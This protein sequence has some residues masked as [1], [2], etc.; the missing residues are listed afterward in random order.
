[1]PLIEAMQQ[2]DLNLKTFSSWESVI[3]ELMA[4]TN[5]PQSTHCFRLSLFKTRPSNK[6]VH[7]E[8][9]NK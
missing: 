8:L 4:C 3:Q 2:I 7:F 5:L 9:M 6:N 1:M